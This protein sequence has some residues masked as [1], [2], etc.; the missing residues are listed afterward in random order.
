MTVVVTKRVKVKIRLI[1]HDV[2]TRNAN[3]GQIVLRKTQSAT[4][5]KRLAILQK[6]AFLARKAVLQ[7]P[8]RAKGEEQETDLLH[9]VLMQG[10]DVSECL[11][12]RRN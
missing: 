10:A 8:K 5:A 6:F 4:I 9:L 2:V 1:A 3:H 7:K 12:I 11:Q